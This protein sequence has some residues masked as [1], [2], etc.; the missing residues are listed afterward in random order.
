MKN[1][2]EDINDNIKSQCTWTMFKITITHEYENTNISLKIGDILSE[3]YINNVDAENNNI[4]PEENIINNK[5]ENNNEEGT[6]TYYYVLINDITTKANVY[7]SLFSALEK[8]A[9]DKN[10]TYSIEIIDANTTEFTDMNC[11]FYGCFSLISLPD[12]FK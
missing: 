12:K 7:K 8:T 3:E 4:I 6:K 5:E 9:I 11:I 2:N 10:F 1:S